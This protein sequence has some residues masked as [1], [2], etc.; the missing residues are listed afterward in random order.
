MTGG[1]AA[2]A[3]GLPFEQHIPHESDRYMVRNLARQLPFMADFVP[4]DLH[5]YAPLE[6]GRFV[7]VA[8]AKPTVR[9]S[10][11]R[12]PMVGTVVVPDH[13]S[14]L[15]QAYTSGE[16]AHGTAGK[17]VNGQP[18]S[19]SAHPLL[20]EGGNTP[21]VLVMERNLHEELRHAET[22]R[23]LYRTAISK[24]VLTLIDA[25]ANTSL[26]L[27][28]IKP[29]DALVLADE[30]DHVLHASTVAQNLARRLG[31]PEALEGL[32]LEEAFL[33]P[34]EEGRETRLGHANPLFAVGELLAGSSVVAVRSI[35]L[36]SGTGAVAKIL[37][38]HDVTELKA[39]DRE[40][41]VKAALVKEV[42]HR[43]KN[44]LQ[45]VAGLLRMQAR[46]SKNPEVKE[47]L[48]ASIARVAS[49]AMVHE[50]LAQEDVGLVALNPLV[51]RLMS[52]TLQ[53]M[54]DPSMRI[55][56][57]LEAPGGVLLPSSQATSVAL[58][59][60]ELLQNTIK[61]A[62]AGRTEGQVTVSLSED[63]NGL[64]V[65]IADD[66]VGMPEGFDPAKDGNLGWRIVDT[67][68]RDDLRGRLEITRGEGTQIRL[69][70]PPGAPEEEA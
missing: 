16:L 23:Q 9:P 11:Y 32:S 43:V 30:E 51:E 52:S 31:R 63:D 59:I 35:P 44:N 19:Q 2:A 7:C 28:P 14:A 66:G 18:M 70:I 10:F 57:R 45:T 20:G 22:K 34:P 8:E 6:G 26:A 69:W 46:R 27:P 56:T 3:W 4:A 49:I 67:L 65:G 53:G 60:N 5:I 37:V 58:V 41:V 36:K 29:G 47:S 15:W 38:L 1:A 55:G 39:K 50:A 17:V 24:L 21:A 54:M 25:A 12:R 61:H 64:E 13:A 40:L 68:V 48:Q 33:G 42:H 62:F